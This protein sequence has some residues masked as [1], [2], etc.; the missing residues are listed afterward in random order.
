MLAAKIQLNREV[1]ECSDITCKYHM[2][3]IHNYCCDLLNSVLECQSRN[4]PVSQS[5]GQTDRKPG[6]NDYISAL[7]IMT[8]CTG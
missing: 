8:L 7:T 2:V 3:D 5:G 4:I 1:S 6:W